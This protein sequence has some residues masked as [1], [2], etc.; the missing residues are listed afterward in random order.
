MEV[1][2]DLVA[3]EDLPE[4]VLVDLDL[5]Q[6]QVDL[7]VV[8]QLLVV[9]EEGLFQISPILDPEVEEVVEDLDLLVALVLRELQ[10]LV[11]QDPPQIQTQVQE[12]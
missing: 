8:E 7:E 2:L 3:E 1:F 11:V 12:L 6:V 5:I 4:E 10:I 9:P